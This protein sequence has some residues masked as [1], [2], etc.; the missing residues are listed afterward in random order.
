MEA[1]DSTW[2]RYLITQIDSHLVAV[3]GVS[4]FRPFMEIVKLSY[5]KAMFGEF[6]ISLWPANSACVEHATRPLLHAVASLG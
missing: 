3:A 4:M 6:V 1:I 2:L 5:I